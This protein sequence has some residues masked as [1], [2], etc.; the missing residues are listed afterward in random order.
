MNHYHDA[1][2][3]SANRKYE[4]VGHIVATNDLLNLDGFECKHA[5]WRIFCLNHEIVDYEWNKMR[6]TMNGYALP[7]GRDILN[8]T[9][10]LSQEALDRLSCS[11]KVKFKTEVIEPE[12]FNYHAG[13]W[14]PN[15]EG[16]FED[17]YIRT[18]LDTLRAYV[19]FR[20]VEVMVSA[21]NNECER[22]VG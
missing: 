13:E 12:R 9:V 18:P 4:K 17:M 1:A 7:D 16:L 19:R 10:C 3:A 8:I 6:F 21:I 11:H 22:L 14:L 20:R 15:A 2:I 5:I